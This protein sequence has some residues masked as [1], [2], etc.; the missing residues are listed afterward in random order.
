MEADRK[1]KAAILFEQNQPLVV[2]EIC[3]KSSLKVGQV[4]VKLHESGICGSQ[5]GEIKGVKG[6]DK[7]LPHLLGHEGCA[8]V[9]EVG[10]GVDNVKP[11]DLVVLHWKPGKG[12]QSATPEYFLNNKRINA[13]WVTTFNTKAIVSENRCTKIPKETNHSLATMFGCAI[14]TAFGVVENNAHLKMGESVVVY[15]AGGIGLNIIQASSLRSAYP[16]IAVDLFENRLNL[17]SELG[18][19]HIINASKSDLDVKKEIKKALD[20]YQLDCFIDNTGIPSIIELGYEMISSDGR[21]VLVGVPRIGSNINI[22]SLQL[23]FGKKLIGSHGGEA[24]PELDIKRFLK[25][26]NNNIY[27]IDATLQ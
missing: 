9:L 7:Y 18:A 23:H 4:L 8:T 20:N 27:L 3:F 14:T 2:E 19:S 22:Y 25:L 5:L 11:D 21:V 17:A 12:I 15:G 16:I 1:F 10:P 13:G 26:F 6:R 24:M